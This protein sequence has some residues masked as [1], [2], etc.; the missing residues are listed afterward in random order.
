MTVEYTLPYKTALYALD[1]AYGGVSDLAAGLSPNDLLATSRCHGWV[2]SDVLFH[3]LGDAQRA[4]IGLASPVDDPPD[5][6]FV[7]YW[8]GYVQE[9]AAAANATAGIWAT[10]RAA[11]AFLDGR[12]AALLWR[13]TAPAVVR[14]AG[15]ADPHGRITTQGHVLAVAD[16]LATLVTEA[17]I[18]HIDM[19]VNLSGAP[20]PDDAALAVATQTLDGLLDRR[21]PGVTWPAGRSAEDY[22]LSATGRQPEPGPLSKLFPLFS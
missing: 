18:H 20:R 19:S 14:A 13:D 11:A 4:L 6:D 9:A 2:V 21:A 3:L 5:R 15:Y 12:G 22:L 8:A 16:F 1:R 17:V 10:K 7:T